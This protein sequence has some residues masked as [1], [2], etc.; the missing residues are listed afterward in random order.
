MKRTTLGILFFSLAGAVAAVPACADTI[1]YNN[2]T[3]ASGTLVAY[4][5]FSGWSTSDAF[6]LASSDTISSVTFNYWVPQG[7]V[8]T[9][10]NGLTSIDW[11]IGTSELGTSLGSGT[12]VAPTSWSYLDTVNDNGGAPGYYYQ[13]YSETISIPDIALGSGT[14]W[15]TLAN[16]ASG[17]GYWEESNGPSAAYNPAYGSIPSETFEIL[18][19]G[20]PTVI[21]EPPSLL[22]LVTGLAGLALALRRKVKTK[23]FCG[24][25]I[26]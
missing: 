20:G 25:A 16:A 1:L 7:Q 4:G 9:T 12:G 14:Y 5:I 26:S 19:S 23:T 6:N 13:V 22:L 18:G 11:S 10:S 2:A 8:P 24:V 21:P 15:L 17:L 3:A